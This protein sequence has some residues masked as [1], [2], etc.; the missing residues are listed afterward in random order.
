MIEDWCCPLDKAIL[1][2]NPYNT[3]MVEKIKCTN[4]LS[5]NFSSAVW[6]ECTFSNNDGKDLIK[7]KKVLALIAYLASQQ[8][9]YNAC[10]SAVVSPMAHRQT[11]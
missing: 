7:M 9:G 2:A 4:H 3:I 5:R 6:A 1:E 8:G 11:F 10:V